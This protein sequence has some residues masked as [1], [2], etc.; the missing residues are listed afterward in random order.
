MFAGHIAYANRGGCDL[1]PRRRGQFDSANSNNLDVAMM[2]MIRV[3]DDSEVTRNSLERL[4]SD[5]GVVIGGL[6]DW[7]QPPSTSSLL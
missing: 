3:P 2:W 4:F 6:R 7:R 1:L 5:L